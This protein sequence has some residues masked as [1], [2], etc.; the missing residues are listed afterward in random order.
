MNAWGARQRFAIPKKTTEV[1]EPGGGGHQDR[2]TPNA[3]S[4]P[5]TTF[6]LLFITRASVCLREAKRPRRSAAAAS[7]RLKPFALSVL[8]SNSGACTKR[9]SFS[10]C[11]SPRELLTAAP[12]RQPGGETGHHQHRPVLP[13]GLSTTS[14]LHTKGLPIKAAHAIP[15]A[16]T[17]TEHL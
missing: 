12:G 16:L 9:L 8:L 10:G 3:T 5:R 17:F 11:S 2:R 1:T 15:L 7:G 6:F 4:T 13:F 14:L